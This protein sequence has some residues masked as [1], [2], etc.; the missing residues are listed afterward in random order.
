VSTGAKFLLKDFLASGVN[1][2]FTILPFAMVLSQE[3]KLAFIEA[4]Y[5]K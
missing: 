2:F 1:R 3:L 5:E 4:Y